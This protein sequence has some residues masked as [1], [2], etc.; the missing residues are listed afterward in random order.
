MVLN[1]YCPA[2]SQIWNFM[3]LLLCLRVLKLGLGGMVPEVDADG[4][5]V[6]FGEFIVGE[7]GEDRSFADS[8]A[9]DEDEFD[10]VIVVLNHV[11][12]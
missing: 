11:V 8:R 9:A 7:L 10:E 3:F 6:V 12:N 4:G 5:E 2:V 1:L